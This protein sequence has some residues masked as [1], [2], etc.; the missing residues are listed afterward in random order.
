MLLSSFLGL[1]IGAVLGLTG[2]GGGILAVPALVLGLGLGVAQAAPVALIAVGM[3]AALGALAGL[4]KGI[5]RYKAAMLMSVVGTLIAPLG[6]MVAH[7]LPD[8]YLMVIF[9]FVMLLVSY[10]M[11]IQPR[12]SQHMDNDGQ[13][14]DKACVLSAQTGRFL[15]TRKSATILASIGATSG[16][17]TGM[18]G[19]GGGF[20]IVPALRHFSNVPMHGIVATSL[21][22]I[23]VVATSTVL[24]AIPGAMVLTSITWAFIVCVILGM[25]L[26]R[27]AASRVSGTILQ[28][29]FA[30]ISALVAILLLVRALA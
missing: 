21:M 20:V 2:A 4:R 26:G 14:T 13:A 6:I 17:L 18:L 7:R 3:A 23:A 8:H 11:L 27:I 24:M 25:V 5:V 10:R 22:V 19:V 1:L 9:S 12:G 28:Q 29:G 30:L 15:W 16:L